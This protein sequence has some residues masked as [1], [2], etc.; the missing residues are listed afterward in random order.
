MAAL[1]AVNFIINDHCPGDKCSGF[2]LQFA[3][4]VPYRS[5][6]Q[7]NGVTLEALLQIFDW[8]PD[9]AEWL[10]EYAK[11]MPENEKLIKARRK[12]GFSSTGWRECKE[13]FGRCDVSCLRMIRDPLVT[14]KS[15][16]KAAR[17]E[18]GG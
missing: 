17:D 18:F 7:R 9:E 16:L 6:L 5:L 4:D 1:G 3:G 12:L 10:A 11:P 15:R 8:K 14:S 13:D 2:R